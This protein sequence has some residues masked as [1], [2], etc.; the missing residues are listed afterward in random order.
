MYCTVLYCTLPYSTVLHC[1]LLYCTVLYCTVLYC[2]VLHCTVLY[3]T[4]CNSWSFSRRSKNVIGEWGGFSNFTDVAAGHPG[5]GA[6]FHDRSHSWSRDSSVG[7][8][9]RLKGGKQKYFSSI[10]GMVKSLVLIPD[11]QTYLGPTQLPIQC[12]TG[13][14][15]KQQEREP[16][17]SPPSNAEVKY[18]WSYA[19]TPHDT[20]MTCS[21]VCYNERDWL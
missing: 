15:V 17:I 12:V 9:P 6:S 5:D 3:C 13:S 20:I 11:F 1:T 4:I 8:V 14:G 2:T 18:G 19:S 7:A 16:D 21:G 10:P